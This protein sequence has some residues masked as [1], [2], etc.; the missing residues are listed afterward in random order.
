MR[1]LLARSF[2]VSAAL[3]VGLG[4]F[5]S[6]VAAAPEIVDR[7]VAVVGDD[8]ILLSEIDEELYLAQLRGQLDMADAEAVTRYR[9]EV[10]ETLVEAK[11][12]LA[13]AKTEGIRATRD[14]VDQSVD[15]MV[16]D[17]RSRFPSQEEFEAQLAR[18]GTS[19]S[20]LRASYRDRVE[21]Q[22][23]VRQLVDRRVRS[24][25]QV[26]EREVRRYWDENQA[27][28]PELPA[29]LDLS[30][31]LVSLSAES[32]VDSAAVQRAQIVRERAEGGEDF[33][34]LAQVFSEGPTA[35]RGGLLGWFAPGDLDPRLATAVKGLGAGEMTPVVATDRGVHIVRVDDVNAAEGTYRLRQIVFLKDEEA[36]RGT[37]SS[38]AAAIHRRLLGGEDFASVA[39]A[40][41]D[42]PTT[43]PKGGS[44]GSVPI[45]SL[46]PALRSAL[47]PL[48]AGEVSEVLEDAQ[49]FA[50]FR[51]NG[52]EGSREPT[53]DDVRERITALLEQEKGAEFYEE[54]V[55]KAREETYVE[56]RLEGPEG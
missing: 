8:I 30:L 42:D 5:G 46:E 34:T 2:A 20:E 19:E 32:V 21:E 1:R 39:I 36:A 33:A 44:L 16:S 4:G 13:K 27:D 54:L 55:E 22:L 40:E 50:I 56:L 52:R 7:V 48:Q 28:I 6:P 38:R 26:D 41:S 9:A 17:V 24:R 51:V 43:A 25:V 35:S 14:E 3:L 11:V 10:L 37:A 23:V 29:Q 18:E 45:E 15:G 49:G 53:F 12:L 31:I 47:E